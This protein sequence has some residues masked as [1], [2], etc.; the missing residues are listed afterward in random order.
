MRVLFVN[1]YF[2]SSG[3][4][5]GAEVSIYHTCRGLMQRGV[6]C[7]LLVLNNRLG[8]RSDEWYEL[9]GIPVHRRYF[10]VRSRGP[11][12]DVFEWQALQAMLAELRA[13]KPD[14]VHVHNV[15]GATLAPYVACRLMGVPVVNTLHDHWLLCPNNMRLRLGGNICDPLQQR[16]PCGSCY[17]RYD[18]WAPVPNRTTLFA[19][20]TSNVKRFISPSQALIDMHVRA[21]YAPERF[22]MLTYGLQPLAED[23]APLQPSVQAIVD[24]APDHH[25][26]VFAGGGLEI[27][28]AGVVLK[29]IP[30]LLRYVERLRIVVAG[31]RDDYWLRQFAPYAPMVQLLGTL[32]FKAM[33]AL[34]RC[35]DLTVVPS[36]WF[37][38][39]PIVIYENLQV[40]T[41]VVGSNF[42]GIPE[43][44]RP[45]QTGYLFPVGDPVALAEQ[46]IL[47]YA[48]SPHERRRMRRACLDWAAQF[49]PERHVE[50]LMHIYDGVLAN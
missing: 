23:G 10:D 8:Q 43:L 36:I 17:R 46:I 25:T 15:S 26:I 21:G 27:K 44:I 1:S 34:F 47:Y 41:P 39:S 14:L 38:N 24:S 20:L 11:Y 3:Y 2:P 16:Q 18:Y 29:A 48:Q 45:G 5:G 42:G 7:S 12:R 4:V 19:A 40:G 50:S 28:G 49:T 6:I 13:F 33:R 32:P 30:I 31:T 9:D 22:T 37:E 35:A